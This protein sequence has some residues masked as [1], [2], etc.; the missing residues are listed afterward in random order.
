VLL[1]C[2]RLYR[3]AT[4]EQFAKTETDGL[5]TPSEHNPLKFAW[6]L[7]CLLVI[8]LGFAFAPVSSPILAGKQRTADRV[9]E[10]RIPRE[11]SDWL[12]QHEVAG[13]IWAPADWTEWLRWQHGNANLFAGSAIRSFPAAVVRDYGR[14]FRG[15]GGWEGV[16]KNYN[17]RTLVIDKSRQPLLAAEVV[18]TNGRWNIV[19]ESQRALLVVRNGI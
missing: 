17:I 7:L 2:S 14:I 11:V 3:A 8:W 5:P 19:E 16:V 13:T 4:E 12:A 1:L 18:R 10:S 6:S 15:D 9:Y